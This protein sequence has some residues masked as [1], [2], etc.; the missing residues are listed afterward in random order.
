[1]LGRSFW[2]TGRRS[3]GSSSNA[4]L[5][6]R[7]DLKVYVRGVIAGHRIAD[8]ARRS[9]FTPATLRY[10]EEIGLRPAPERSS[11]GYRIY[12]DRTLD[13]LAFIARAK[14]LGCT[15]EEIAD[16]SITWDGG[17][18]GPIQTGCARWCRRSWPR[19]R[20]DSSSSPR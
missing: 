18:C 20:P 15:L 9:G 19:P 3:A 13:R 10:Y 6:L 5:D 11:G 12:D 14:Q 16:L 1:M 7:V 8:V 4:R 17:E 2:P